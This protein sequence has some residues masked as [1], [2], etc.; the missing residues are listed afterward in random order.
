MTKSK[1]NELANNANSFDI[2]D[3][4]DKVLRHIQTESANVE[5][6]RERLNEI[7]ELLSSPKV[8]VQHKKSLIEERND[9]ERKLETLD[10]DYMLTEYLFLTD[11]IVK[12]Y[13][14]IMSK[15]KKVSF[16]KM[17]SNQEDK[18]KTDD[19]S[20]LLKQ[21]L[22]IAKNYLDIDADV[23]FEDNSSDLKCDCGDTLNF[24]ENDNCLTC[25][26]C[27]TEH[28]IMT[29]S[30]SYKDIQR[31][32]MSVK[33]KYERASHFR[34]SLLQ[35]QGKQNKKINKKVF[36][37]LEREFDKHGLL[38]K[39][40]DFYEKH[41]NITRNHILMFLSE[42]GH[43]KHYEDVNLIAKYYGAKVHDISHLEKVLMEDFDTVLAA[44]EKLDNTNR[45]NFLNNQYVLYQLLKRRKYKCNKSDFNIIESKD[46][47]LNHDE[48]FRRI[49]QI[50][51]WTFTPVV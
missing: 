24:V 20:E 47:L 22:N 4:N 15:P 18:K 50:C 7:S 5:N 31:I 21:F 23:P 6:Y 26:K 44:Y 34:D 40:S 10:S 2:L 49:C 16:M 29:N 13:A 33:Y 14:N 51:Q 8:S 12:Q 37:D 39:S 43:N 42:V 17:A 46:R 28:E 30:N 36:D 48:I 9:I 27:G 25:K 1:K 3:L 11:S 41:K 38:V 19:K 32:N 45:S 35:L